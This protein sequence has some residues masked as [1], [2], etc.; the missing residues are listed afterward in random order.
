MKD[1]GHFSYKFTSIYYEK[2]NLFGPEE[3]HP[4]VFTSVCSNSVFW[5]QTQQAVTAGIAI[6]RLRSL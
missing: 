3:K 5:T 2:N 1:L 6:L 4:L